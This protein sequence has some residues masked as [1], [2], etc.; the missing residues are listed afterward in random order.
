MITQ[1][2]I[3]YKSE[4][5]KTDKDLEDEELK[6]LLRKGLRDSKKKKKANE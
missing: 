1:P 4:L 5:V 3:W 6:A 2:P